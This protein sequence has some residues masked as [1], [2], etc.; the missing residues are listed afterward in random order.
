MK[1]MALLGMAAAALLLAG[2]AD[3]PKPASPW[4]YDFALGHFKDI[5]P[6]DDVMLMDNVYPFRADNFMASWR[7]QTQSNLFAHDDARLDVLLRDY[8]ATHSGKSYAMTMQMTLR[9][10]NS[11]G[12]VV[13]ETPA[14][15]NV[16]M[17]EDPRAMADFVQQVAWKHGLNPLTT[18]SLDA[19]MWQ[20]VWDACISDLTVQFSEALSG[21][22][23]ALAPEQ[24]R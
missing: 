19:T 23:V 1:R 13:A 3:R 24:V 8:V 15:C 9:G 22:T 14:R 7:K 17:R 4:G 12:Q 20:K 2:C 5:R 16:V 11:D 18:P 6:H 21:R 10:R